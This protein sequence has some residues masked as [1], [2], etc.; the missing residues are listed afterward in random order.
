MLL[1][2]P[3]NKELS[4]QLAG[5]LALAPMGIL[6][7]IGLAGGV[8]LTALYIFPL[9]QLLKRVPPEHRKMEPNMAWLLLIPLFNLVWNFFVYSAIS[10]SYRSYFAEQDRTDVGDCG[11]SLGLAFCICFCAWPVFS[12][13]CCL[14]F[15]LIPATLVLWV[16][17][18][19]KLF[20]LRNQIPGNA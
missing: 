4:D 6:L 20:G 5:L 18:L 2:L 19:V 16:I 12:F 8:A 13:C 3:G 1:V 9:F 14:D 7:V 17:Y 10:G 15:L 11:Q